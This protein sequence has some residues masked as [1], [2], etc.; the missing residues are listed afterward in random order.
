MA[1]TYDAIVVG[2]RV[3]R[4]ADRDAAGPQG[5]Q[6]AGRRPGDVPERHAL[7]AP[8]P[9]A[10]RRR[11]AALGAARQGRRHGLPADRHLL[12]R[13]RPVHDPGT[14]RPATAPV[15]YGPRRTVL[16]KILVDAAA[17]A[18]A[19]VREGF[20]V[21]EVVVEDGRVVGIRGHGKGGTTVTERARVVIG[22]DGRNSHVAQGGQP[23]Q[24]NEKPQLLCAY[25]TYWSGLPM[26]RPIRDLRPPRPR[27]GGARRRTTT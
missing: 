18:G 2:A 8:H 12:V 17:E 27:L 26:R 14:P 10:G 11:A 3:R 5:L 1:K 6:G 21:D 15:A 16:D 13:L 25:Y 19:E 4:I 7:D 24:Y 23:E 22:A 9:P 20:T